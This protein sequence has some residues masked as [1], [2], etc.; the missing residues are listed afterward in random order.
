ML[1][2]VCPG[3]IL[4]SQN[5]LISKNYWG[6][7]AW[8][9]AAVRNEKLN[10]SIF[11]NS[12]SKQAEVNITMDC[13]GCIST[14]YAFRLLLLGS[15]IQSFIMIGHISILFYSCQLF[16]TIIVCCSQ[17]DYIYIYIYIYIYRDGLIKFA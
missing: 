3:N 8:D 15:K 11:A 16:D 9:C 7:R 5:C 2:S 4:E 14:C 17:L 6:S 13:I 12:R 1:N 10:L